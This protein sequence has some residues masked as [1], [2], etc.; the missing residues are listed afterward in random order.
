MYGAKISLEFVLI[1]R[2]QLYDAL[3]FD[4]HNPFIAYYCSTKNSSIEKLNDQL[5]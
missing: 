3:K 2:G 1:Y 4:L 5:D